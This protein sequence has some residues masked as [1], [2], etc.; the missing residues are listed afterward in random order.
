MIH[1]LVHKSHLLSFSTNGQPYK[2]NLESVFLYY[3]NFAIS[4]LFHIKSTSAEKGFKIMKNIEISKSDGLGKL[5]ERFLKDGA[6][7]LSK[8]ICETSL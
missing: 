5:R 6:E 1:F 4:E 8:P 7:I 3:S 2:C